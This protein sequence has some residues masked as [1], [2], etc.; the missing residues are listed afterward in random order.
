MSELLEQLRQD[1]ADEDYRNSYSESFMNS[2]VAAQIKILRETYP[3]TQAELADKIGTQQPGV[4]RLENVNYS[5]WKVETLR[6][7]AR[8][9]DVRLKI[10]FEEFGTLIDD[11]EGFNREAILRAPFDRDPVFSPVSALLG[12][13]EDVS[14]ERVPPEFQPQPNLQ[15]TG[16]SA[17]KGAAG[18]ALMGQAA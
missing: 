3:L 6:K 11:V 10:T 9:L 1:F 15:L 4:A 14:S 16:D 2:Y 17:V 5:A 18:Q 7:I 8:A 13:I 12:N